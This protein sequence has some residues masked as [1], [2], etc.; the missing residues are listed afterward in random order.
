MRALGGGIHITH[1][2][3]SYGIQKKLMNS[4]HEAMHCIVL[5][6]HSSFRKVYL[7]FICIFLESLCNLNMWHGIDWTTCAPCN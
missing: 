2:A 1:S 6:N 3:K 5:L 7:R 4:A